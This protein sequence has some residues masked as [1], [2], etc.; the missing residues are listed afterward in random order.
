VQLF[1]LPVKRLI[2]LLNIRK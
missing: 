2:W 1:R